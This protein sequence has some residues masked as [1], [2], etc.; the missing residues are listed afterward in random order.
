MHFQSKSPARRSFSRLIPFLGA[1]VAAL[2][3]A[4]PLAGC[5]N[6]GSSSQSL[7]RSINAYIP[8]AGTDDSLTLIGNGTFLTGG[9]LGFGQVANGGSY[10]TLISGPF[11]ADASGPTVTT[12]IQLS[13][14]TLNGSG[15]AYT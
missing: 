1:L 2:S 9:N 3:L 7:V 12:P 15:A 6:G 13:G 4:F 5:S 14:Q 11:S 10:V 8:A